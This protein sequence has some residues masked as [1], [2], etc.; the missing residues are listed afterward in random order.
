MPRP[1]VK[2]VTNAGSGIVVLDNDERER[3]VQ[4]LVDNGCDPAQAAQ[5]ADATNRAAVFSYELE[6]DISTPGESKQ[7]H[8]AV[9]KAIDEGETSRVRQLVSES[10]DEF[11]GRLEL[12]QQLQHNDGGLSDAL[13]ALRSY[14]EEAIVKYH[15]RPRPTPRRATY[16]QLLAED[17]V[18]EWHTQFDAYPPYRKGSNITFLDILK[19]TIHLSEAIYCRGWRRALVTNEALRSLTKRACAKTRRQIERELQVLG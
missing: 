19:R 2:H 8:Q 18:R 5:Y 4:A 9:T 6:S 10:A 14:C 16:R 12:E 15:S 1:R 17:L 7:W 3:I 11:D 13:M